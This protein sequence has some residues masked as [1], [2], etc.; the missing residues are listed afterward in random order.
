MLLTSLNRVYPLLISPGEFIWLRR[1][2]AHFTEAPHPM[3]HLGRPS[4]I[5]YWIYQLWQ[6][7]LMWVWANR[8]RDQHTKASN[9]GTKTYNPQIWRSPL[10]SSSLTGTGPPQARAAGAAKP[11]TNEEHNKRH[12]LEPGPGVIINHSVG[13]HPRVRSLRS[14]KVRQGRI[15][16]DEE[17]SDRNGS[18]NV[19]RQASK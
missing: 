2:I 12:T 13:S 5:D 15:H 16:Q 4:L 1:I 19:S 7:N 14:S 11:K 9:N 10:S 8:S 6:G 17:R 18:N 3:S